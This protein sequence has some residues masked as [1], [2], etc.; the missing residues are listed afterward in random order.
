MAQVAGRRAVIVG[1]T[2]GIG[3]GIAM[4]L[5]EARVSVTIVGRNKQ[6][7]AEV[8]ES[9]KAL[10]ASAASAA[11]DDA[12]QQPEFDF[13]ECVSTAA[14][15]RG[16]RQRRAACTAGLSCVD[17]WHRLHAGL[18]ADCREFGPEA[19]GALLRSCVDD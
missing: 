18:H 15:A 6:A 9:M 5:A 3:K 2:S 8:V 1:G 4:R 14:G 11:G 13:V 7:G 16:G 12:K 10:A 19:G 17:C